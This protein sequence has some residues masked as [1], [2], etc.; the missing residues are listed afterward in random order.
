MQ[1]PVYSKILFSKVKSILYNLSLCRSQRTLPGMHPIPT[2][3]N[4]FSSLKVEIDTDRLK[5]ISKILPEDYNLNFESRWKQ[6]ED[7]V[8]RILKECH[9]K[10]QQF[11]QKSVVDLKNLKEILEESEKHLILVPDV[12]FEDKKTE[13]FVN[14]LKSILIIEDEKISVDYEQLEN[15]AKRVILERIIEFDSYFEKINQFKDEVKE[16]SNSLIGTST[17]YY[18]VSEKAKRYKVDQTTAYTIPVTENEDHITFNN[19][20]NVFLTGI[21]QYFGLA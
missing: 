9:E 19:K 14:R 1:S 20:E 5:K 11:L 21:G 3:A 12:L 18:F 16:L 2:L 7:N 6:F 10:I 17:E 8:H 4:K 15:Y 13:E